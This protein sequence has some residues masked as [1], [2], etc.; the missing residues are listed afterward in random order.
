MILYP[1]CRLQPLS[2]NDSPT[3]TG[4]SVTG[5]ATLGTVDI[6]AGA[7]DGI[8][9]GT[10]SVCTQLIVDNIDINGNTITST[11]TGTNIVLKP[12]GAGITVIGDAG[13]TSHGLNT[14]DCL[15][16]TDALEVDGY[17]YF[18]SGATF[19]SANG[20][21]IYDGSLLKFS[22]TSGSKLT[23]T[24]INQLVTIPVGS[25]NTPV[26]VSSTNLAPANSV[27]KA[28]AVRVTQAP[29]GGATVVSVGRTNGGN[30][31]EFIDAISTAAGTIGNHAS[32]SDG[33]LTYTSMLQ[34]AAD[35]F[36]I[37]TDADVTGS[38]MILRITVFYD[39]ITDHTG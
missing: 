15:F 10:N 1:Y 29:G 31:D 5:T 36:D 30:T 8:T 27:I 35:T 16:V 4:L 25:G 23:A 39:F 11:P 9:I 28:V 18:D 6:N 22:A 20:L 14:N 24:T 13:A 2:V 37:T 38:D 7:I 34:D 17:V 12:L 21:N 33:T 26:V 19:Y 3:F 32:N